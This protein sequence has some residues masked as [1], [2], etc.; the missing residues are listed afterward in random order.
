MSLALVPSSSPQPGHI[1]SLAP[2]AFK[3]SGSVEFEPLTRNLLTNL[4]AACRTARQASMGP[5]RR[6]CNRFDDTGAG[7]Q[8]QPSAR[9]ASQPCTWRPQAQ[10]QRS[11]C[12]QDIAGLCD[13]QAEPGAPH[14]QL[15][16]RA[17]RSALL[18]PG[19]V[20]LPSAS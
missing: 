14:A 8:Q 12:T 4:R 19:V 13:S 15:H 11:A 20:C 9:T 6:A 3:P 18:L 1:D 7:A 5:R 2:G 17:R 16:L 10:R